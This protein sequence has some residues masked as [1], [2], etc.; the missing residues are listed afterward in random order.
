[1]SLEWPVGET[2]QRDAGFENRGGWSKNACSPVLL[3]AGPHTAAVYSAP[4]W[5]FSP[6]AS[7]VEDL[8]L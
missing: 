3:G 2:K 8:F 5:Q 4:G 1:M 6:V 7:S